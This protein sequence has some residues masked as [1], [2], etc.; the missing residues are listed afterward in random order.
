[1][2]SSPRKEGSRQQTYIGNT[3]TLDDID[4]SNMRK[5]T[6]MAFGKEK[7]DS[8]YIMKPVK[9][10]NKVKDLCNVKLPKGSEAVGEIDLG[11]KVIVEEANEVVKYVEKEV[12]V[13]ELVY[14]PVITTE[15]VEKKVPIYY[16]EEVTEDVE[17]EEIVYQDYV[18][19]EYVDKV[20]KVHRPVPQ[21]VHRKIPVTLTIPKVVNK[22]VERIVEVPSGEI[23][24][25][26]VTVVQEKVNHKRRFIEKNVPIVVS[27]E[28]HPVVCHNPNVVRE[29]EVT[30]H[31]PVLTPVDVHVIKPVNINVR[32]DGAG[33]VT[34]RVVTVPAA[35]YNT[36]LK[37]LNPNLHEDLPLFMEDGVI[38]MLNQE[39]S[40]LYPPADA[41]IEGFNAFEAAFEGIR[42]GD[43][44]S[45]SGSS[46]SSS[47]SSSSSNSKL[48]KKI[49]T[50]TKS[51]SSSHYSSSYSSSS[52]QYS[53][54]QTYEQNANLEQ[55]QKKKV[56]KAC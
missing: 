42:E 43:F 29:V 16:D 4:A 35:H 23:V 27:H 46:H 30:D 10:S 2:L 28:I 47:S 3:L 54:Y 5:V 19:E 36:L 44:I 39:L 32:A 37:K 21:T 15:Y 24:H 40:F 52:S 9:T 33:Q 14:K 53:P 41:E 31:Y 55:K 1:M 20:V 48:M 51:H 7:V 56:C 17:V 25:K 50:S 18:T 12:A 11:H 38:P 13:E 49:G 6:Q 45:L 26:E 8:S 22:E 34:H